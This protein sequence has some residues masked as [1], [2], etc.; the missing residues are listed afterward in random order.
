M[1]LLDHVSISVS[2]LSNCIKFYDAIMNALDC[3]KVYETKASLG[4]GIRCYAGE[5][6]HSCLAVYESSKAN[7]DD[8]RHWCFKAKSRKA[9]DLFYEKGINN[10]GRCDGPPG[11]RNDYHTSY[12]AAFL[13]DPFGDRVEAVCHSEN[14]T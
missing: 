14:E 6:G 7:L 10:G 11:L 1:Q 12:Y 13:Y 5:E 2:K 8:A 3:E 9:V 4:Y